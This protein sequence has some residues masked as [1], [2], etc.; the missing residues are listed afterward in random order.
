MLAKKVYLHD[1]LNKFTKS[2]PLP[3]FD[4][5]RAL[6][7]PTGF[8]SDEEMNLMGGEDRSVKVL[9]RLQSLNLESKEIESRELS[10]SELQKSFQNFV[11]KD[12]EKL[13]RQLKEQHLS[14][15]PPLGS[16]HFRIV[17]VQ[18]GKI[19]FLKKRI[20]TLCLSLLQ[21]YVLRG[22]TE[23]P[24]TLSEQIVLETFE[25]EWIRLFENDD[26]P[27]DGQI[28]DPSEVL[29]DDPEGHLLPAIRDEW[30]LHRTPPILCS[31]MKTLLEE[32]IN[33]RPVRGSRPPLEGIF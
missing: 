21:Q 29:P 10:H 25:D 19:G 23:D 1:F 30:V 13:W 16:L 17:Y 33:T 11:V 26:L 4:H 24:D 27:L 2:Q 15:F 7:V 31:S 22:E 12:N 32:Q 20:I 3:G 9:D 14:Q 6:C 28:D 18:K 5:I 8:F